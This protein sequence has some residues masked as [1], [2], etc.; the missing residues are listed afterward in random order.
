M[1][2]YAILIYGLLVLLGGIM[3]YAK[4][5]STPSLVSG[6]AFGFLLIVSAWLMLQGRAVGWYLALGVSVVLAVFFANRFRATRAFMPA[7]LMILLSLVA[8]AVLLWR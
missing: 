1:T 8:V 5:R 2:G 7:G 3:G 6:S 4:A